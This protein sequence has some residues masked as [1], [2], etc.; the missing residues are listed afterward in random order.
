MEKDYLE[1]RG[2][3]K[4]VSSWNYKDVNSERGSEAIV[5]LKFDKKIFSNPKPVGTILRCIQLSAFEDKDCLILDLFA[6]S[7]TTAHAVMT[8]NAEDEGNRKC[9]LVQ[10]PEP[11]DE[12]SEAYKAGYTTIAE[13]TK[14]RIRRAG[15]LIKKENKDKEGID[16]LDV[17]FRVFKLDSSNIKAWDTSVE[18]FEEQLNLFAE[19]NGE[20]IKQDRT[21]ED[22]LFEILLKYGLELTVPIN[23]KEIAGNKVYNIGFGSM[24]ICL[25][26][27]VNPD[28]AK[29]IGEWHKEQDAPINPSIIFKDAGFAN[30]ADKTN[31]VQ[32]LRQ[33]G[34]SNV[35]SI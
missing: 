8:L 17:G 20:N 10:L 31:T 3:I 11:T 26:D 32:T 28:V 18:K 1:E 4:P 25:A 12:K 16:K 29:G 22:I 24:Y 7:G 23:E 27:K 9:I 21:E 15:E 19:N 13:I 5:H 34:I 30:D 14:E 6:G 35:K 33:F 2:L